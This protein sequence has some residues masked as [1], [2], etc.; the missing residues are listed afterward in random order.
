MNANVSRKASRIKVLEHFI[1]CSRN[2]ESSQHK[3]EI[4]DK[5]MQYKKEKLSKENAE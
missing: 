5:K 3:E 2:A 4:K 1:K